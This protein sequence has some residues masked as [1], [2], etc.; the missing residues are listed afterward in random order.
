MDSPGKDHDE[1]AAE[2]THH[3]RIPLPLRHWVAVS[4]FPLHLVGPYQSTRMSDKVEKA[5]LPSSQ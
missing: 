1:D 4:R 3:D 5:P 2:S